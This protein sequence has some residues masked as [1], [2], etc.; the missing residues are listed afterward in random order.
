MLAELFRFFEHADLDLSEL[1][2]VLHQLFELDRAREACRSAADE[3]HVH[4]NGF[5]VRLFLTDEL[6]D[7]KGGLVLSRNER[8]H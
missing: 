6:V 2:V 5:G 3:H 1:G 8:L 4:G 7:G